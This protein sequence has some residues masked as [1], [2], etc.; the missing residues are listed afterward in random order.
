MSPTV[1]TEENQQ[2]LLVHTWVRLFKAL[3]LHVLGSLFARHVL[4]PMLTREWK[5]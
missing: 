5:Y 3:L 1:S 2:K 4:Q